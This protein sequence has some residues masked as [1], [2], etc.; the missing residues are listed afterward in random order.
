MA[1]TA[2]NHTVDQYISGMVLS[3]TGDALGYRNGIWEFCHSG[4]Q[5]HEDL[6][7]LGGLQKIKVKVPDW[8]ISDDTVLHIAT[9][10]ALATG[11]PVGDE[12]FSTIAENYKKACVLDMR[13]RAPGLTTTSAVHKLRPNVP[14]G[15][16]IPF[17]PR[18]G[19]CGAAMRAMCIGLRFPRQEQLSELISVGIESGRMTHHHPTGFLGSLT[20]ALFTSYA[21]QGKPV[22]EWGA[23]L[24]ETLPKAMEYIK[25]V[26]RHVEDNIQQWSYFVDRWTDYL[27]Q[28]KIEDGQSQ[29]DFPENFGVKERDAF[30]KSLSFAGW[31]GASGHDAPMIAYDALLGAGDD[32]TEFCSRAMFHSGDSDSTAVIGACWWG[33]LYGFQ[34]VPENNYK[35]VEYH[36]RIVKLAEKLF[37]LSG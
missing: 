29:P 1:D 8:I 17:N 36:D 18:G 20:S 2:A 31:G 22:I 6:K 25:S 3:A 37:E 10:E 30:Y 4:E 12:L 32:W 34:G 23:G 27:K 35:H 15:Y 11:K 13:D 26:G 24:L 19:G 28:R 5:I 16:T 7:Q 9:A 21:V 14:K 33:V